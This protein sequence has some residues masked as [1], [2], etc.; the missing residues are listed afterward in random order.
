MHILPLFWLAALAIVAGAA[1]VTVWPLLRRSPS[2]P[3][4]LPAEALYRDEKRQLDDELAA[5]AIGV[6]EHAQSLGELT[7]RLA[8]ELRDSPSAPRDPAPARMRR[9]LAIAF[10][11]GVPVAALLLYAV[12]G[13]P[14][15]MDPAVS[16]TPALSQ[17]QVIAMVD[18]LAARMKEHPD[19]AQGWRLLARS[20]G[21]LGRFREAAEAFHE[22]A[23]HGAADADL[24]ADW[25]DALGMANGQTLAGEPTKLIERA[26]ALDPGN[27]KAL[28]LAA[29]AAQERK[30]VPA[31]IDAWRRL[32]VELPPG[33]PEVRE[34]DALIARAEAAK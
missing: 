3:A 23:Q 10:A 12:L 2:R 20:Y 32:K 6:T 14:G 28:L 13:D 26:L 29:S 30:D 33:S 24:L 25:A 5:G 11:T 16:A 9:G 34:I 18:R 27:V 17:A 7:A 21:A 22:A 1:A 19:D 8:G 15:A 4:G 31:A